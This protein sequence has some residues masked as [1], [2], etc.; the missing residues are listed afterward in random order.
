[1]SLRDKILSA[2]DYKKELYKV[3]KWGGLELELR[4]MSARSRSKLVGLMYEA[5]VKGDADSD[6][7]GVTVIPLFPEIVIDGVFDPETGQR[8]FAKSDLE[9]LLDKDGDILQDVALRIINLSAIGG[10]ATEEAVKNFSDTQNDE[11]I[12]S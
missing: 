5:G 7:M 6:K 12:T 9:A 8:V 1:M 2:V 4:S 10:A 3:E 11:P